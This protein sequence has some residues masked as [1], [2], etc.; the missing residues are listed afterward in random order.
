MEKPDDILH[1]MKDRNK[2]SEADA[3]AFL[4][5]SQ[6]QHEAASTSRKANELLHGHVG[7]DDYTSPAKLDCTAKREMKALH[8]EAWKNMSAADRK[9]ERGMG[10]GP[11]RCFVATVVYG[12]IDAPEVCVLRMF[13]DKCLA[14]HFVG[15]T[16]I[17]F[18]YCGAGER[19][20]G[21]LN[22]YL[23]STIPVLRKLLN[24]LV[25]WYL[26]VSI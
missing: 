8:R 24:H 16:F 7:K 3:K 11:K 4:A 17:R 12:D 15:R 18:Y 25:R 14:R 26:F 9:Y 2:M 6:V 13:R 10:R 19:L 23:P 5:R 1:R 20:A 21:L 22:T